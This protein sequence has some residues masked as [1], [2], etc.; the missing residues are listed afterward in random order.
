MHSLQVCDAFLHAGGAG[1]TGHACNIPG[2]FAY[3]G[4]NSLNM[5]Q[6][7]GNHFAVKKRRT[8][9]QACVRRN[10]RKLM[11]LDGEEHPAENGL[12]PAEAEGEAARGL[13]ASDFFEFAGGIRRW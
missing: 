5:L 11:C 3:H 4:V 8:H 10:E 2:F 1:G 12:L 13:A 9:V 6:A 7:C